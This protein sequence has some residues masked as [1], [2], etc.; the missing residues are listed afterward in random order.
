[1]K[2]KICNSRARNKVKYQ[3]RVYIIFACY[4]YVLIPV[5]LQLILQSIAYNNTKFRLGKIRFVKLYIGGMVI[6]R[7]NGERNTYLVLF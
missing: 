7:G 6:L 4:R 2:I 5:C 1:M 3:K